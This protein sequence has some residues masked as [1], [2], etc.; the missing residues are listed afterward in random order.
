MG[1]FR[2]KSVAAPATS[3]A[4]NGEAVAVDID[5]ESQLRPTSLV[6]L[7]TL[8]RS[9]KDFL[10]ARFD[11]NQDGI[12]S[13]ADVE[14]AAHRLQQMKFRLN[15]NFKRTCCV[16]IT[17]ILLVAISSVVCGIILAFFF[18]SSTHVIGNNVL[19]WR[20]KDAFVLT[21][22]TRVR[23]RVE[24]VALLTVNPGSSVESWLQTVEAIELQTAEG[25]VLTTHFFKVAS[26]VLNGTTATFA[27]AYG[28][29]LVLTPTT[30]AF[31]TSAPAASIPLSN[32]T[33]SFISG[34]PYPFVNYCGD[35]SLNNCD[36]RATCTNRFSSFVCT[37]PPGYQGPGTTC[38][39]I[40][41]CAP[42]GNVTNTCAPVGSVCTNTPG[43]YTCACAAGYTGNGR[44]CTQVDACLS[45]PCNTVNGT[46]SNT[47]PGNYQCAC[48]PGFSGDGRI[49]VASN[50]T[51]GNTTTSG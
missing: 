24:E 49:C 31:Q 1:L 38:T 40:N 10:K 33:V 17:A 43:S 45:R 50:S 28:D 4:E 30:A 19:A 5:G 39:D 6:R 9:D 8:Q 13:A 14:A 21:A 2:R 25:P 23:T 16:L 46:C 51:I 12:M 3:A 36:P 18:K 11:P 44:T 27:A 34:Q 37:C 15:R 7:N 47:T 48:L 29:A 41:E 35:R 32:G 26:T 42:G 20:G 22:P